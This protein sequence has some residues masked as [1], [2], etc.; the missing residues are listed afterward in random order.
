MSTDKAKL[1]HS[2]VRISSLKQSA[3][4][5]FRLDGRP[6]VHLEEEFDLVENF[7]SDDQPYFCLSILFFVLFITCD[8]LATQ[9]ERK[10]TSVTQWQS[11]QD[12][13]CIL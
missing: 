10:K 9:V 8:Y 11:R 3:T 7:F 4:V 1:C 2:F 5:F 6:T 12:G 13:P